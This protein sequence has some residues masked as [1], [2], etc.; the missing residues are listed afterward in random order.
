MKQDRQG[1]RTVQDLERKYQ[2]NKQFSEVMGVAKDAQSDAKTAKK[3]I[4]RYVRT[5]ELEESLAPLKT[6][7]IL[8][9]GETD[10]WMWRKWQSGI[11]ECW[12]TVEHT[13]KV[14]T[15]WGNLYVGN[16]AVPRQNYP[17]VFAEKPTES[18]ALTSGGSMGMIYPEQNGY[19]VNGTNATAMYNVCSLSSISTDATF[20]FAYNIKGKWR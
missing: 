4:E 20:Y 8:E 5:S 6:D 17:F 2:F 1:A 9:M 13:T 12:K 16:T 11:A 19:G 18:V 7:Y 3:K 15:A 10:G 14:A